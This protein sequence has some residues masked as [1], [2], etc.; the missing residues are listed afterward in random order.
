MIKNNNNSNSRAGRAEGAADSSFG[1]VR[2]VLMFSA[3]SQ[4]IFDI[5][6]INMTLSLSLSLYVC[7][8]VY[9]CV[10]IY[11]YMYIYIYISASSQVA[12]K[13]MFT[14]LDVRVSSLRRGRANLPC[15]VPTLTD[16]PRI[17]P[18]SQVWYSIV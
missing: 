12:F 17:H 10:Y 13:E 11:I 18:S 9:V 14:L 3:S 6:S 5:I 8:Y 16:D 15:V 2:I 7:I 1:S 4:V